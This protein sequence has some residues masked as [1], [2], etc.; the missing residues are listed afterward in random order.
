MAAGYDDIVVKLEHFIRKFYKNELLRGGILF[1]FFGLFYFLLMTGLEYFFWFGSQVRKILF[2]LFLGIELMLFI[3]FILW[4]LFKLIK[5]ARGIDY[6]Q[7]A[8]IIGH[9]F[10]E[11]NDQLINIL[12]LKKMSSGQDSDLL[13]AGIDQKAQELNPIPFHRAIHFS[14]NLKYVKFL[15]VPVLIIVLLWSFGKSDWYTRG[16]ERLSNYNQVYEPPAPFSFTILN[17]SLNVEEGKSLLLQV[18]TM[19]KVVP[20]EVEIHTEEGTMLLTGGSNSIF[21]HHFENLEETFEFSLE[22]NGVQSRVYRIQV[23]S[24]PKMRDLKMEISYP[25]YVGRPSNSVKGLQ[26]IRIPEGSHVT[27]KIQGSHVERIEMELEKD[28]TYSF[29]DKTDHFEWSNTFLKTTAY[30]ISSSNSELQDYER[31]RSRIEVVKDQFPELQI[32]MKKDSS[33][34][35]HLF[36]KGQVVDDYGITSLY[37]RYHEKD[38]KSTLKSIKIPL[39][40]STFNEFYAAFPDTISLEKGK[41]YELFFEVYDNDG[42]RGPKSTKS[43]VFTLYEKTVREVKH[44]KLENSKTNISDFQNSLEDYKKN[45]SEI[46]KYKQNN[47]E[48][49]EPDFKLR[50][51]F[52]DIL[53]RENDWLKKSRNLTRELEKNLSTLDEDSQENRNVKERLDKS[54]ERLSQN[55]ELLKEL[56]KYSKELSNDKLN[57][58]LDQFNHERKNQFR[59]LESLLELTKRLYVKQKNRQLAEDLKQLAERQKQLGKDQDSGSQ[60]QEE[61]NTDFEEW[62]NKLSDL[63]KENQDLR[64]PRDLFRDEIREQQIQEALKESFDRLIQSEETEEQRESETLKKEGKK[65]QEEGAERMKKLQED[66]DSNL[67]EMDME[68]LQ[69]DSEMLRRILSNLLIFSFDQED[70]MGRLQGI[71]DNHPNIGQY[72]QH[73]QYLKENFRHVDDSLYALA[74]RNSMISDGIFKE[75]GEVDYNMEQGLSNLS[76]SRVYNGVSNQR[77]IITSSNELANLLD[78]ALQ[79]MEMQMENMKSGQEGVPQPQPNDGNGEFQLD[80]IIKSQEELLKELGQDD[81]GTSEGEGNDNSGE[82]DQGEGNNDGGEETYEKTF[83]IYK[84]QAEL[85]EKMNQLLDRL[86]LKGKEY[87]DLQQNM[88]MTEEDI[89]NGGQETENRRHMEQVMDKMLRLREAIY[90]KEKDSKREATTNMKQFDRNPRHYEEEI[91]KKFGS[92]E[93]LNRQALPLQNLYKRLIKDYFQ[94]DD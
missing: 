51:S 45:D 35:D 64:N 41:S 93:I 16:Y 52:K 61:L 48:K 26:N 82:T 77:Y 19:G 17:E 67:Q 29:E 12:Q 30:N 92:E 5:L 55:E 23:I 31:L 32:E 3:R 83:E 11:A 13:A 86:E 63:E 62:R 85:R 78:D 25:D 43:E 15:I 39:S 42:I 21:T 44:E 68:Q 81:E 2:W 80:D 6:Y 59:S 14:S 20:E 74:L 40:D 28:T 58:K 7:A 4:P 72:I 87:E 56:E 1:L 22:A 69:E 8:Q 54:R 90:E 50:N 94:E 33:S 47:I 70:L 79:D 18:G 9:H 36:F 75:I 66:M 34:D 46:E 49:K 71:S 91:K 37:L 76:K 24:T 89:L 60:N 84:Q 73:Q 10:P 53:N 88:E 38:G 57:E 65:K 27:W